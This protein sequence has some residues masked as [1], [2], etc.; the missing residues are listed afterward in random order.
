MDKPLAN[1]DKEQELFQQLLSQQSRSHILMFYG[2]SG[3]GKSHLLRHCLAQ[4]PPHV[5]YLSVQLRGSD[6]NTGHIFTRLGRRIGWDRLPGFTQEVARLAGSPQSHTDLA[7]RNQID[8][9]LQTLLQT[10]DVAE[11]KQRRQSLTNAWF[12]DA[13]VF[14][15]PFLLALDTYEQATTELEE[16]FTGQFL[17]WVADVDSL[18]VMVAGQKVPPESADWEYCCVR[19]ELRGVADAEAWLPVAEEMGYQVPS[20][21]YLAGACFAV[22]GNPS[23]IWE[24]IQSLPKTTRPSR[25]QKRI[26]IDRSILRRN[27]ADYFDNA[28]LHDICFDLKLDYQKVMPS[29]KTHREHIIA[30]IEYIERRGRYPELAALCQEMRPNLD[31]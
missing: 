21:D 23:K 18:R 14:R 6:T 26:L 7:W 16:W 12:A 22:D 15:T 2:E 10:E 4:A 25:T 1:Y 19:H 31:W 3:S 20:K 27:L 8:R 9:H 5:G 17:P 13:G 28:D 30:L 11:R 24:L 29:G